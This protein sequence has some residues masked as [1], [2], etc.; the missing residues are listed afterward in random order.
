[1]IKDIITKQ[2]INS[3][4]TLVFDSTSTVE[5]I[6]AWFSKYRMCATVCIYKTETEPYAKVLIMNI[7]E[8]NP[9][10]LILDVYFMDKDPM[11]STSVDRLAQVMQGDAEQVTI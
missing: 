7:A 11:I 9:E 8:S 2:G 10:K 5:E 3:H 1:M 4:R 6:K